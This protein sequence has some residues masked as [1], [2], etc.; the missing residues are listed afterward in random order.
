MSILS[1]LPEE[2]IHE[3]LS[4]CITP[5]HFFGKYDR[6]GYSGNPPADRRNSQLL[7]VSKQWL[8]I[9][10][11]ILYRHLRLTNQ[12]RTRT[13]AQVLAA[14]EGLGLAIRALRL[15]G[16]MGR[17]LGKIVSC[18]PNIESLYLARYTIRYND[19]LAGLRRALPHLNVKKLYY[20]RDLRLHSNKNTEEVEALLRE[21]MRNHWQNIVSA[22]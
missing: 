12:E 6:S 16:G 18:A 13:V 2:T 8:R 22:R 10:T 1:N 7:L 21:G 17:E 5:L 20:E 19:S 15:E 4:L 11:P 14:N 9:G 3:I